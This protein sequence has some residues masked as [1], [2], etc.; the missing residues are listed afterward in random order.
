M[1][2]SPRPLPEGEGVVEVPRSMPK[3][4]GFV[5]NQGLTRTFAFLWNS[6]RHFR[7]LRAL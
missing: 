6:N 3:G 7:L 5:Y 1:R 2:P 4:F